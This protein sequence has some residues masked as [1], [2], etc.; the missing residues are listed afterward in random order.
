MSEMA[1]DGWNSRIIEAVMQAL[2]TPDIA[3]VSITVTG[4][5]TATIRRPGSLTRKI[6]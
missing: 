3:I 5:A 6:C 1:D 4:K 2:N